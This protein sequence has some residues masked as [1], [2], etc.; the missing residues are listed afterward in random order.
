MKTWVSESSDT[1][2]PIT[3]VLLEMLDEDQESSLGLDGCKP[4][5]KF[6]EKKPVSRE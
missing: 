2:H 4:N 5:F 6:S 1:H 3:P